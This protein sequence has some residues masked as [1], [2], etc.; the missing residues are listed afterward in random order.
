M[1]N[2]HESHIDDQ[3]MKKFI[4]QYNDETLEMWHE[5]NELLNGPYEM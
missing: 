3:G 4:N 1:L 2:N 5:K